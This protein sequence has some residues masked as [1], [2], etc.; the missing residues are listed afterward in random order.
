M[1][2]PKIDIFNDEKLND[3]N[4]TLTNNP[5]VFLPSKTDKILYRPYSDEEIYQN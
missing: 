2:A 5:D 1:D 3:D 4:K